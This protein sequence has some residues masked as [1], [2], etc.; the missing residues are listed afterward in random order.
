MKSE[1]AARVSGPRPDEPYRD[2]P[3]THCGAQCLCPCVSSRSTLT[4]RREGLGWPKGAYRLFG[5]SWSDGWELSL[6]H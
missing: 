6:G 4:V 5:R 1:E 3:C 2:F